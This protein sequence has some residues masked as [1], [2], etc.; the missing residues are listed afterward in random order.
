MSR[1]VPSSRLVALLPLAALAAC[2]SETAPAPAPAPAA[3][4]PV[5]HAAPHAAIADRAITAPPAARVPMPAGPKPQPVDGPPVSLDELTTDAPDPAAVR[6]ALTAQLERLTRCYQDARAKDPALEV[7]ITASLAWA[8]S[9]ALTTAKLL[10]P[11]TPLDACVTGVLRK[12]ALPALHRD[13]PARA[14]IP[15]AFRP[16]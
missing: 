2:G 13:K 12:V 3:A 5:A 16:R 4:A 11:A 9:G 10:G 8:P 1:A 7:T 6:A 15:I 14:R